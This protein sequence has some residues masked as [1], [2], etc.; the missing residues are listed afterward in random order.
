MDSS[1]KGQRGAVAA[2]VAAAS[3]TAAVAFSLTPSGSHADGAAATLRGAGAVVAAQAS[4][5]AA[6]RPAVEGA[7]PVLAAAGATAAL[8]TVC[9]GA[10]AKRSKGSKAVSLKARGGEQ[11]SAAIPFLRVPGRLTNDPLST[12]LP[13]DYG[14]DPLDFTGSNSPAAEVERY[15]NEVCMNFG[16]DRFDKIRWYRESE[17]MHGRVAMLACFN[18]LL[19]ETGNAFQILPTSELEDSAASWI[20]L[21]Q[22]MTV[23]E[24]YRGYRLLF[25]TA[26]FAGDIGLGM[27]PGGP[28]AQSKTIEDLVQRQLRELVNGRWAMLGVLGLFV[29]HSLTGH[30][31]IQEAEME[32]IQRN[33][34]SVMPTEMGSALFVAL[35]A[36]IGAD[37]MRRNLQLAS[38][39]K[40]STAENTIKQRAL[41]LFALQTGQ[42]DPQVPLPTGVVAHAPPQQMQLTEAQVAQFQQDGVIVLKGAMKEWKDYLINVTEHQISNP[43]VWSLVGRMSG[44]YDYIQRN[45]WMTNNGIRDFLYYSPLSHILAQ[46][47]KTEEIR[48]TTDLLLV[49]PNK[50]FAWHQDNQNG[51][52]VHDDCIRFWVAMDKCGED[53]YGA[54]EYLL[55]SHK[56]TTVDDKAVFVDISEGDLPQFKEQGQHVVEPGDVIIWA[57]RTIHR[58]VAPPTQ[59]WAEGTVRRAFAG[60]CAIGNATYIDQGG[61]QA[62]SNLAG[63]TQQQ[64]QKLDSA[65]FPRLYPNRVEHEEKL[66]STGGLIDRDPQKIVDMAVNLVSNAGKYVSFA[67]VVGKKD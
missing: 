13:G 57:S 33:I 46:L 14:F 21:L 40:S 12:T 58:I 64:G 10:G 55:G 38:T 39:D 29:Q 4:Q 60:T 59:N 66:R 42:Q 31:I 27:G 7:V 67:K 19:R 34:T 37:G 22:F 11:M 18:I 32:M 47:A 52:I 1:R 44:L 20:F 6:Q 28:L 49:N 23:F 2:A 51:P 30:Y 16:M 53:G 50:G 36:L 43:H 45:T 15:M 54:P 65:Y 25:D 63:H 17:L 41:N 24:A 61:A 8:L 62:I 48:I 5:P 35:C 56:N 26:A 9:R 3:T